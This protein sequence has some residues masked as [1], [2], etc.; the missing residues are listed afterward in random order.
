MADD[1]KSIEEIT[2]TALPVAI[3]LIHKTMD[4]A[5]D[6]LT[7][8]IALEAARV[9]LV[10]LGCEKFGDDFAEQVEVLLRGFDG[11]HEAAA[12]MAKGAF[13]QKGGDA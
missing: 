8:I 9:S 3:S 11:F 6:V 4:E 5:P 12:A 10:A 13:M 7:G 1:E 2:E